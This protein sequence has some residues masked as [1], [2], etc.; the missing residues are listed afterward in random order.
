M[1]DRRY[2]KHFHVHLPEALQTQQ[3]A[4]VERAIQVT[5]GDE[6]PSIVDSDIYRPV[7]VRIGDTNQRD[8]PERLVRGVPAN[9]IEA[10]AGRKQLVLPLH[11]RDNPLAF[12][13]SVKG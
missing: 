7:A 13:N 5:V 3:G 11:R 4:V 9:W 6:W 8:D 2:R 10:L 1:F 12:L